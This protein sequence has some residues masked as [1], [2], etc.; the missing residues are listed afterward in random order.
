VGCWRHAEGTRVREPA[1]VW[2]RVVL[3]AATPVE[4]AGFCPFV[5]RAFAVDHPLLEPC[6]DSAARQARIPR[7]WDWVLDDHR[8]RE[9]VQLDAFPGLRDYYATSDRLLR[10]GR[11]RTVVGSDPPG[12][13][14]HQPLRLALPEAARAGRRRDDL[15][16]A[17]A[18]AGSRSCRPGR[19]SARSTPLSALG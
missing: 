17:A 11:G 14:P 2:Q 15:R 9:D 8:R 10:A 3:S 16:R 5:S 1:A 13:V 18:P 7:A 19:A 12:Y 4:L 6:P